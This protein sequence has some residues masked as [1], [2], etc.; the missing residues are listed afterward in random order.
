MIRRGEMR[1]PSGQ[2][3]GNL[4]SP[5]EKDKPTWFVE[6]M[7][8]LNYFSRNLHKNTPTCPSWRKHCFH[9][10]LSLSAANSGT[11]INLLLILLVHFCLALVLLANS[12]WKHWNWLPQQTTRNSF[13]AQIWVELISESVI[14]YSS[15]LVSKPFWWDPSKLETYSNQVSNLHLRGGLSRTALF[16]RCLDKSLSGS[17]RKCG[18]I[19]I[20][21]YISGSRM[22]PSQFVSQA[23]WRDLKRSRSPE[24]V[25]GALGMTL[26]HCAAEGLRWGLAGRLWRGGRVAGPVATWVCVWSSNADFASRWTSLGDSLGPSMPQFLHWGNWHI[27]IYPI[28]LQWFD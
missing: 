22:V 13:Q 6:M 12:I 2:K 19:W 4:N 9:P 20:R 11:L 24:R 23:G 25:G 3:K 15:A 14:H 27:Y 26:A 17:I 16:W 1:F 5:W 7:S 28:T 8:K 10:P 21:G 18:L